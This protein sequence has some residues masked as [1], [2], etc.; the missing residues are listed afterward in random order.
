M[1]SG[2]NVTVVRNNI[3]PEDHFKRNGGAYD[4]LVL[5][6]GP[7]TPKK[8]GYSFEYL[9]Y[10]KGKIPILGVC[11]GMQIIN[12]AYGGETILANVPVHGKKWR[13]ICLTSSKLITGLRKKIFVARYHSL[14]CSLPKD[15]KLSIDAVTADDERI[16]MIVSDEIQ[17]VYAVQ[18]HPESYLS[19]AG[20]DLINNFV[21]LL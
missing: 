11:L 7:C 4:G 12:E 16:P 9:N 1:V 2:V 5:S 17:K 18:F 20:F 8:S 10:Y 13:I 19:E 21:G 6:P 15:S 3:S 14:K